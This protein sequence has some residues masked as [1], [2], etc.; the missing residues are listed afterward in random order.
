M[1]QFRFPWLLSNVLDAR[2]GE[3]LGGCE[4][5]RIVTWQGV[6]VGLMGLVEREVSWLCCMFWIALV[7]CQ[8]SSIA[9][10]TFVFSLAGR[11]DRLH[12]RRGRRC[13]TAYCADQAAAGGGSQ[14]HA[15]LRR[16]SL[17]CTLFTL[18]CSG[19]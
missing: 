15:S 18:P 16:G 6:R 14:Q 2:T 4:R 9:A 10:G 8:R 5:S 12:A 3:P 17:L 11:W 13:R 1:Q 7:G 19:C